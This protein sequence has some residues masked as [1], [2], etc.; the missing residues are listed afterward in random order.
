MGYPLTICSTQTHNVKIFGPG[1]LKRFFSTSQYFCRSHNFK[2]P[3]DPWAKPY[4]KKKSTTRCSP[5]NLFTGSNINGLTEFTVL[6][7]ICPGELGLVHQWW[8]SGFSGDPA[9]H[10]SL[11]SRHVFWDV[12]GILQGERGPHGRGY[13]WALIEAFKFPPKSFIFNLGSFE[14][15]WKMVG[16]GA[17]SSRIW[18]INLLVFP[19]VWLLFQEN[20]TNIPWTGVKMDM[21]WH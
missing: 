3:W 17:C 19:N 8:V 7:S 18:N 2:L 12:L 11:A 9:I 1:G 4:Q 20:A 5:Q 16:N 6:L 21:L 13:S 10:C 14:R 15:M